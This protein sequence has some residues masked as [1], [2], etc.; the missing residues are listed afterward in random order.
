MRW[1]SLGATF[2]IAAATCS[3]GSAQFVLSEQELKSA[4]AT[5]SPE[6]KLPLPTGELHTFRLTPTSLLQDDALGI[7]NLAGSSIENSA[8]RANIILTPKS[9]SAQLFTPESTYYL[10]STS[11]LGEIRLAVAPDSGRTLHEYRCLTSVSAPK[12]APGAKAPPEIQLN[13][14]ANVLRTFRLAPAATA[15]FTQY[16][17]TREAAVL[18][19]VTAMSRASAIF[20]RELGISFTLVPGFE[21]MVFTNMFKDPYS[22]NDPSE[23]LLN[24]A[25]AAF[26]KIIGTANYDVGILLTRG[27]YGLAYFSTVGDPARKGSSCIGL[28]KPGGDAFHVNLVTHELGHQFGAKHTFNSPTGFCAERRDGYTAFEPGTGSTIMSYSSLPCAGDSFQP[29]HDAYFHSGNIKQ[30]LDF[31]NGAAA[32]VGQT[33]A[34]TNSAPTINAGPTYSI[35]ARTPFALTAGATDSD[36]DT[37]LVNW[38][39]LDLGPARTLAAPDDGKGPLFRSIPPS[40]YPTRYFPRLEL[41]LAGKDAPEERLP[42]KARTMHFRAIARDSRDTGAINWSDT[43]LQVI[44]TGA[45]FKITSHN[46]AEPLSTRATVTWDVAGT[47]NSPINAT[48]VR[49]T[50]S[51]ND[52]QC[53]KILLTNSTPNNGSAEIAFPKLKSSASAVRLKIEPTNNIFFDINDAPLSISY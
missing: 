37:V 40:T 22:S 30:I 7:R 51:T 33:T 45:P 3:I 21:Q 41:I 35:P 42:T 17:R 28:P 20:H 13:G 18:E 8:Y 39:Q 19:V 10:N 24:E 31:V 9:I 47:T 50:L 1:L 52:G 53:F 27:Q 2:L 25:Q 16:H 49:L 26:D 32:Q 29:R 15:E 6:L 11:H 14:Y 36:G 23:Q 34:R 4:F 38:E 44:D 43:E 48:H 12:A 46:A 5:S